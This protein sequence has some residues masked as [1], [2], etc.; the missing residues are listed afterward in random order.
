MSSSVCNGT[1]VRAMMDG[2]AVT[3]TFVLWRIL[4]R[5]DT[6]LDWASRP[7]WILGFIMDHCV[8]VDC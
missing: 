7:L 8:P 1:L 2:I 3:P 5:S 4:R 6:G